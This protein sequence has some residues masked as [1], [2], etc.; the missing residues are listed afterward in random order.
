MFLNG[1]SSNLYYNLLSLIIGKSFSAS[2]LGYYT[3]AK[4]LQDIPRNTLSATIT[5]VTFPV[6]SEIQNDLPRLRQ[7]AAKCMKAVAFI[8]FPLMIL[9]IVTA[10]P[11]FMLLFTDKW[12]HAVP[13][14]Q[15]LCLSGLATTLFELNTNILKALGKSKLTFMIETLIRI[16]GVIFVVVGVN[17]GVVGMLVGYTLSQYI[18]YFITTIWVGKL[19]EYGVGN[20]C[21]DIVPIF[22]ASTIPAIIS[23]LVPHFIDLQ[24]VLLL[25]IQ[26]LVYGLVYFCLSKLFNIKELDIYVNILKNRTPIMNLF[27]K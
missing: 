21:K 22:F 5:G 10:R 12:I 24:Y 13:Y 8:N 4:K 11:L 17:W 9:L 3:Q 1:I 16:I 26:V 27:K 7:V 6:F 15:I 20:Q 18:A 25:L 14:F 2:A 23:C 19:A